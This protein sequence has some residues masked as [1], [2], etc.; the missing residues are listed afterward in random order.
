MDQIIQENAGMKELSV[1][2][3]N[4]EHSSG[5]WFS[6]DKPPVPDNP[7]G[8]NELL[9]LLVPWQENHTHRRIEIPLGNWLV[10][11][12]V[13]KFFGR[14]D[15]QGDF[16]CIQRNQTAA[17]KRLMSAAPIKAL[18]RPKW[19]AAND[20]TKPPNAR[21]VQKSS[22]IFLVLHFLWDNKSKRG[23][24]WID[25]MMLDP[26]SHCRTRICTVSTKWIVE[27]DDQCPGINFPGAP[28]ICADA[29][30]TIS[31]LQLLDAGRSSQQHPQTAKRLQRFY[32]NEP[33][34]LVDHCVSYNM[35]E[36]RV[37][38]QS[39][40]ALQCFKSVVIW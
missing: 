16:R 15:W 17:T 12:T 13:F 30:V 4:G 35:W 40:S 27:E 36:K 37:N 32:D 39:N 26:V 38:C 2:G 29:H 18:I 33:H 10:V 19:W 31:A 5:G 34:N 1:G 6:F 3:C 20:D 11:S 8:K 9:K 23:K 14:P 22:L 7:V 24:N 28:A 25:D 21:P